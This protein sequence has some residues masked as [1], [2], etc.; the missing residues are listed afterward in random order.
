MSLLLAFYY[1]K[2]E[3]VGWDTEENRAHIRSQGQEVQAAI[4]E[5]AFL[6]HD[7]GLGISATDF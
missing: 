5:K 1:L 3:D 6:R 4:P 7:E 2:C